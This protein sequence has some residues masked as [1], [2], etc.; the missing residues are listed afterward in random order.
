MEM[1]DA[2]DRRNLFGLLQVK[3]MLRCDRRVTG[4]EE[5]IK[6][7]GDQSHFSIWTRCKAH[8]DS[9]RFKV[10][11]GVIWLEGRCNRALNNVIFEFAF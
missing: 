3:S 1:N 4:L 8:Q 5:S 2:V 10:G 6:V 7:S 9:M 11:F